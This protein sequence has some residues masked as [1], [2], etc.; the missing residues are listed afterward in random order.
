MFINAKLN[1]RASKAF[2]KSNLKPALAKT[3]SFAIMLVLILTNLNCNNSYLSLANKSLTNVSTIKAIEKDVPFYLNA[4]GKTKPREAISIYPQTSGHIT[5]IHFTDGDN[6]KKG[7]LLFTIDPR[8]LEVNLQQAQ[9]NLTKDIALKRQAEAN[10]A[11]DIELAQQSEA[12]LQKYSKL[13]TQG[14]VSQGDYDQVAA[15][16]KLMAD[17]VNTS[18][19]L[20]ESATAAIKAD[21]AAIKSAQ[22]ELSYT[23]VRAPM[24]GRAGQRFAEVGTVVVAGSSNNANP[25]LI[26]EQ[27]DPIYADF[28]I[29]QNS[30]TTIQQNMSQGTLKVEACLAN[31]PSNII[32]GQLMFLDNAVQNA[33][34]TVNLRALLPNSDARFTPG[35]Y[36]QIRLF[37]NTLQRAVLVPSAAVRLSAKGSFIYVVKE[38]NTLEQRYVTLGQ[39][40]GDLVIIES[41]IKAGELVV[42]N[43]QIDITPGSKVKLEQTR[44]NISTNVTWHRP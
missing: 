19:T 1:D 15:N 9:A 26:M 39:P 13:I 27:I 28:P 40:Q 3:L 6:I 12:K 16:A 33:T 43:N 34:G 10:L 20:L 41:G 23:Y 36:V 22:V 5:K 35:Q 17:N 29:S 18:R 7:D 24:D 25:L 32:T 4:I 44:T 14:V 8:A 38:D 31:E 11:R 21:E 37:L 42:N 30:L 2:A